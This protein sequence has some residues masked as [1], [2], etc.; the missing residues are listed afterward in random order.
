MKVKFLK[1]YITENVKIQA[2]EIRET[3]KESA[4]NLISIGYAERVTEFKKIS[5]ASVFTSKKTQAEIFNNI[6]PIFYDKSGLWWLWCNEEK[7]WKMCD[8]VDILNMIEDSTGQDIITSKARNETLNAL[9]QYGRKNMPNE[10]PKEW[11]CFKNGIIDI[12][13]NEI[14]SYGLIEPKP[15]YFITNIIPYE[16]GNEIDTPTMD[17]IFKEWVGEE[18]VETL[19]EIIAYCLLRD[20]PIN[21]IFCF[22]GSGLNGKSKYLELIKKFIGSDNCTSTEL[23]IL[24]NSRFE[25][26]KLHNKLVCQMGETNFNEISKTSILKKL[27]GGDLIGFEYKNKLPFDDKNYAKILISTNNLPTTTDKTIGF[28]RRWMIIDFY[29]TFSEKKNILDDIPE[30]EFK[31]LGL[32]CVYIL[33]TL[34]KNREF[35]KEGSIEERQKRYEDRSDPIEKFFK[36][37]IEEDYDGFIFK[38]SFEKQL[39]AWLKE[40]RF[41]EVSEKTIAKFMRTKNIPEGRREAPWLSDRNDKRLRSW[42][43]IR[44]KVDL[45]N[46]N[47]HGQQGQDGQDKS[48][49]YTYGNLSVH[50]MSNLSN[51]SKNND[52]KITEEKI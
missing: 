21:R 15:E 3:S 24:L 10:L 40:N 26:T 13:K 16:L 41:R 48:T 2:G 29:N 39:S 12:S 37:M 18:Y 47:T 51:L 42:E 44:W 1:D 33:R 19:Y 50:P 8:E 4:E 23:D 31:A 17:K 22:I 34:L 30:E 6:Q 25:I 14:D 36:E 9:K 35:T 11:I 38:F 43:G 45:S 27:S 32:K 52:P 46:E 7:H 20:Y 5:P 49:Y 28:F